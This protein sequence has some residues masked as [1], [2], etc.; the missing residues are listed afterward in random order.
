MK[1]FREFILEVNRPENGTDVER[2][3]WDKVR[4]AIDARENPGDWIVG[5]TGRDENGVQTYGIKRKSSRERQR[6]RRNQNLRPIS[7]KEFLDHARRNFYP[8]PNNLADLAMK[9]ERARKR[10]QRQEAKSQS[11]ETGKPYEVDH[12]HPQPNRKKHPSRW[13]VI[14]PGDA[15]SNRQVI[16]RSDNLDKNSKPPEDKPFLTRSSVISKILQSVR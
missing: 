15:S 2:K 5:I 9:W 1:T 13:S 10:S 4:A 16:P 14:H 3:R 8:N 6:Q 12:I 11:T 7:K